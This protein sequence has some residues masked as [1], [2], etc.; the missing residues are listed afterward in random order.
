MIS[1]GNGKQIIR[2]GFGIY[3]GQIFIN[4]PLFM[5]Q[6]VNPTLFATVFDITSS[7]PG[8][9]T[10][11]IVPGLNKPLSQWRY[12]VDPIPDHS[13]TAHAISRRRSRAFDGP[14][15]PQPIHRT[16]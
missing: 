10:A 7:G 16:I 9:P 5:L 11:G 4:I 15:L 1:L 8:D 12:G 3:Y 13:S 2:G 6:Q 14:V